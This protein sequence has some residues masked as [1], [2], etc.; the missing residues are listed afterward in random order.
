VT[1]WGLGCLGR[2]LGHAPK[3]W[4]E[5]KMKCVRCQFE[6]EEGSKFCLECGG[7]LE[8]QC[9]QCGKI[10]PLA[11][12]FCNG[13]GQRLEKVSETEK[14]VSQI[15]SERKYVT[16]LFSD[17]S[18][19]T[20]MSEKLDPEEV[21]ETTSRIFGEISQIVVKYDGFIE[22]YAGDAV[23][24]LFGV[25]KAHEDDPIRAIKVARKIHE[26]VEAISLEIANKIGDPISMHSGIN[27][28]LVVTGEVDMERGTHGVAGDTINMASRLCGLAKPGEILMDVDT[29][30]QSEGH[31]TFEALGLT[32]LKG[33][34]EPVQVYKVLS[35]RDKPVTV[36]RLSGLRA[37]LVGRKVELGELC[38]AVESLREGKGRVFSICGDA[39]TGK[40]RLVE[41]FKASLDL[42]EIQWLEGHAY[43]HSQNIPY[44]PLIDLLNRVLHIEENNPPEKVRE[45]LES[46]IEQLVGKKQDMISYVGGLYSLRY[47]EVEDVSPEFWKSHLQEAIQAIFEALAKKAP[48]VF[49][50]EDLHWAD[51][52]FVELLR[53][54]CFA[55]LGF[56]QPAIFLCAYRPTFSLFTSHQLSGISQ[57]YHE[58]R[59]EDLSL[60]DA[61][62]MLESL[63]K[64]KRLPSELRRL[65]Q[66]K[67]EGNP[68]YLEELVNSLIE[69]ETL[70]RDNGSW[71]ITRPF[72]KS[73]ISSSIHGLISGR[74][75]RLEKDTKRILQEAS[76]IGRTFLYEI[77]MKITT[78]EK[79]IERGL[80]TLERLDLIRTR[81]L[82]P[83][84]EYMFKHPLTQEV[85]YNGL[86][87][88]ERKEIHEQIARVMESLFRDRLPEFYETLAFHFKQGQSV[89]KAV[90]YLIRSGEKSLARY[91][92]QE[93]HQYFKEAFDILSN[94]P[95]RTKDEDALLIE[96]LIKWSLVYY[97]R[98]D[99]R[100][101]SDLL[102]AHMELAESLGNK[103]KLGMFYA[104]YGMT[105][106]FREKYKDS[107]EYLRKALE[108]GED[109]QDQ[110]LIGYA[111]TWLSWTCA[112]LGTLEEAIL[113]AERAQEIYKNFP[114]DQYLFFKSLA[115]IGYVSFYRGDGEKALEVGTALLNY[116]Q[117]HS[118]I[119]SMVM[120]HFM[121][122]FSFLVANDLP[123]AIETG[124]KAVQ[125]AQDPLY[126]MY[127]RFLL[128]VGYI[129]NGQFQEAEEVLQGA[130]SDSRDLGCELIGTPT[131]AF[132]G[133]ISIIRGQMSQGLEMMEGALQ[134]ELRNQR[135]YWYATIA[136]G[137]GQVYLQLIDKDV[138]SSAKRAEEYF[139]SAS[140][141]AEEIG[142]KGVEGQAYLNLGHLNRA[143]GRSD[144]AQNFFSKA[145][146]TFEECEADFFSK[147]AKEALT[148]LEGSKY[149]SLP[150]SSGLL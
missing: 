131:Q 104:W 78:L 150:S 124:K 8:L 19:Y 81:S 83:D 87:K 45:K 123:A 57:L 17:L 71:K 141:V 107:Y 133:L 93:S 128:G 20:A 74:L 30:R 66:R 10:L 59:L 99:S 129:L 72:T 111:C 82:Q 27:T 73:D 24:V 92:V 14:T 122:A 114:S 121:V 118:N 145:I 42:E 88:K 112:E 25:P 130:A 16:V 115:A 143:M 43:A 1:R 49:F 119:R 125:T 77:L 147:Q 40:S 12:K 35:Q 126:Y 37:D 62:D 22:K 140:E 64:A 63:L 13:C 86:L 61:Q 44:F 51:P 38:D 70:I 91:A 90:D 50:M 65:V 116:G 85:V 103:A 18:G 46:G 100:E 60:S 36:H 94:K 135:R 33:K 132:L 2:P 23:M 41:E 6:N 56:R 148:S 117:K 136:N 127:S 134:L 144:E 98:G 5:E 69:S 4:Q 28:G 9:P 68:F 108:M 105:I 79:R 67:A 47:S 55:C 34:A 146:R 26:C 120:G 31:F 84:L 109:I 138:P 32:L 39:G 21:K 54:V 89:L 29:Y 96:L 139:N 80:S 97:Y 15:E 53:R 101:Q 75:D 149:S 95:D 76:V 137:L 48:T 3:T 142:A 11:A 58:I 102:S 113:Y 7:R 110:R 106:W 52:S